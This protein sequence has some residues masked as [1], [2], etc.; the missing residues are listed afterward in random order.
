MITVRSVRCVSSAAP[1]KIPLNSMMTIK[2]GKKNN[3]IFEWNAP[4]P[5][6]ETGNTAQHRAET[7]NNNKNHGARSK[8]ASQKPDEDGG[9]HEK[10]V[11]A[12][13]ADKK[14]SR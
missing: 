1:A 5:Q 6:K 9:E 2:C 13:A 7:N 3:N 12:A 8:Q 14:T 11:A 10:K 4:T